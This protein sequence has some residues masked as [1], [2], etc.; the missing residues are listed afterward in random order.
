M[1]TE[2]VP[3]SVTK[4]AKFCSFLRQERNRVSPPFRDD[5]I[6]PLAELLYFNQNRIQ[7]AMAEFLEKRSNDSFWPDI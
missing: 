6:E 7:E 1:N 4:L 2:F 3:S 5:E